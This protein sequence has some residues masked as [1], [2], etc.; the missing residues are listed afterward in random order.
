MK[1]RVKTNLLLKL[2]IKV[3]YTAIYLYNKKHFIKKST[4]I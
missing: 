1:I 3:Y 4:M 2:Y